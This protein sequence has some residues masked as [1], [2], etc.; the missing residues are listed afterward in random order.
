[1]ENFDPTSLADWGLIAIIV[2]GMVLVVAVAGLLW[3]PLGHPGLT[4]R[5]SVLLGFEFSGITLRL[6]RPM[7][8][9]ERKKGHGWV[10]EVRVPLAQR[11]PPGLELVRTRRPDE[12]DELPDPEMTFN[13][14]LR[15]RLD[16]GS[17]AGRRIWKRLEEAQG[18]SGEDLDI[19]LQQEEIGDAAIFGAVEERFPGIRRINAPAVRAQLLEI[20]WRH[21]ARISVRGWHAAAS[22]DQTED[23]EDPAVDTMKRAV[24]AIAALL[25][26]AR[27]GRPLPELSDSVGSPDK[28]AG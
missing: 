27:A 6:R 21:P 24:S 15:W 13:E 17:R 12:Y 5:G 19:Y 7:Q 9:T 2:V 18:K 8:W 20:W 10:M 14:V 25:D 3:M 23:P 4:L 11:L 16:T 22:R 28:N 26:A 1:M